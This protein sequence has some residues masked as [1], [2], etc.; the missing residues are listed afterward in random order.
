MWDLLALALT[1]L[2]WYHDIDPVSLSLNLLAYRDVGPV[3][4]GLL[5][6]NFG[7]YVVL[8]RHTYEC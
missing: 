7:L 5:A 3:S 2:A 8:F 1:P 4:L 6:C